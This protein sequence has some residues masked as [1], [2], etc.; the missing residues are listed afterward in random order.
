MLNPSTHP[1]LVAVL[2]PL[3][4][5]DLACAARTLIGKV[6]GPGSLAGY[7]RF[8]AGIGR[9]AIDPLFVAVEQIR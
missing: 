5:I 3:H 6:L 9:V 4:F 1:R 2:G 8:L 7:Q